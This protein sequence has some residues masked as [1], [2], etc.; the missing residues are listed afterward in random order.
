MHGGAVTVF[1]VLVDGN[2][3]AFVPPPPDDDPLPLDEVIVHGGT[4]TV[5]TLLL[6][7]STSW[8]CG[9]PPEELVCCACCG[10]AAPPGGRSRG[11]DGGGMGVPPEPPDEPLEDCSWHGWTATVSVSEDFG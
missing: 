1:A 10:V 4:M 7:G 9:V 5:V 6:A 11:L 3:W 8:F 2:A